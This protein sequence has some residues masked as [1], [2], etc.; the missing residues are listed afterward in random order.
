M[1][2]THREGN[3]FNRIVGYE[4]TRPPIREDYERVRNIYKKMANNEETKLAY[5]NGC[6]VTDAMI[7]KISDQL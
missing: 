5:H 7:T 2:M 4:N 3:S 1:I 6:E